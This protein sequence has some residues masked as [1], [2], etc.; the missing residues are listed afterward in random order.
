MF[1]RI[2]EKYLPPYRMELK[3]FAQNQ[4]FTVLSTPVIIHIYKHFADFPRQT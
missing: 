2:G 1:L 4:T 3:S